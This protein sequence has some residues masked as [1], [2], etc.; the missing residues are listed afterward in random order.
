MKLPKIHVNKEFAKQAL[1]TTVRVAGPFVTVALGVRAGKQI[2]AAKVE[3]LYTTDPDVDPNEPI[4]PD[5]EVEVMEFYE[6]S[7]K[8]Q[9][10]IIAPKLVLP[11]IAAGVT[12]GI[13]CWDKK[14]DMKR[15]QELSGLSSFALANSYVYQSKLGDIDPKALE[16][17]EQE[18]HENIMHGFDES[19]EIVERSK[20]GGDTL[21]IDSLTGRQFLS[22]VEQVEEAI[23]KFENEYVGTEILM[24]G[25]NENAAYQ[26]DVSAFPEPYPYR[27]V[28]MNSFY[29]YNGIRDCF[30]GQR[31]GYVGIYNKDTEEW[32]RSGQNIDGYI[33]L[34]KDHERPNTYFIGYD[35]PPIEG[36]YEI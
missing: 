17:A 36:W 30:F 33:Y 25:D 32:E 4:D 29:A 3:M 1:F 6:L 27:G 9:F 8:E 2:Q 28:D 11:M 15:I 20:N 34:I 26:T 12:V 13:G 14:T 21:F 10:K 35:V 19:N 31:F 24:D 18:T 16:E 23:A 5:D 22:T 7:K